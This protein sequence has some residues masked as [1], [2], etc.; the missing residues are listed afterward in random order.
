MSWKLDLKSIDFDTYFVVN[1]GINSYTERNGIYIEA[2]DP[3]ANGHV[4]AIGDPVVIDFGTTSIY[5]GKYNICDVIINS[6]VSHTMYI[7]VPDGINDGLPHSTISGKVYVHSYTVYNCEASHYSGANILQMNKKTSPLN[8][9]DDFEITAPIKFIKDSYTFL[10]NAICS[11]KEVLL[12]ISQ[13][14]DGVYHEVFTR[15][16]DFSNYEIDDVLCII[17]VSCIKYIDST[18]DAVE[19]NIMKMN[20]EIVSAILNPL[21][22]GYLFDSL[23]YRVEDVIN[24]LLNQINSEIK[25][26]KSVLLDMSSPNDYTYTTVPI[27]QDLPKGVT[28]WGSN[29]DTYTLALSPLSQFQKQLIVSTVSGPDTQT[30]LMLSLRYLLDNICAM[31]DCRYGVINGHLRV[32]HREFWE[33]FESEQDFEI[34]NEG[35][36]LK[37]YSKQVQ[38][39]VFEYGNS[40]FDNSA[41]RVGSIA[42]NIQKGEVVEK[43]FPNTCVDLMGLYEVYWAGL[44]KLDMKDAGVN[45]FLLSIIFTD[46]YVIDTRQKFTIPF[47]WWDFLISTYHVKGKKAAAAT[48]QQW[49]NPALA[50]C[51]NVSDYAITG[52]TTCYKNP[53][54]NFFRTFSQTEQNKFELSNSVYRVGCLND[55]KVRAKLNSRY[56]YGEV[57]EAQYDLNTCTLNSKLIID[58]ETC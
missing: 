43:K 27:L 22:S 41:T 33:L 47:L 45:D 2:Y 20:L 55:F 51:N 11:D 58:K 35:K 31:F 50:G 26:V 30:K 18:R 8:Y 40:R 53:A 39:E 57:L 28:A 52:A 9:E 12:S 49:G 36:I 17:S 1:L 3:I 34:I 48:T 19:Y 37:P 4:F 7:S 56:S 14:C 29:I 46:D 10:K 42:Y 6:P 21:V 32:E 38:Q 25:P 23:N 54:T 24:A 16:L 44:D 13:K 15:K 5:N